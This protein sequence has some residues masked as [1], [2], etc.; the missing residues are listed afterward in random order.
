MNIRNT[1]ESM[2]KDELVN[3]TM[4]L[5]VD[6]TFKIINRNFALIFHTKIEA[7]K[8]LVMI[9]LANMHGINHLKGMNVVDYC[10]NN[11]LEG[12]RSS[13]TWIRWG[14]DEFVVLLNSGDVV[15]FI[16]RFDAVMQENDLYATYGIVSTSTDLVESI[17]RAD[18]VVMAAKLQLEK[19]GLKAGRNDHYVRLTSTV[20]CE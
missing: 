7:S 10:I 3:L 17:N 4:Q 1:L 5:G 6:G 2:T 16:N 15:D 8:T 13:D 9:D 14:S 11:V 19:F 12:F 18:A 20:V